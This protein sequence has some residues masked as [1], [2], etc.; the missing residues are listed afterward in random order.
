MGLV[1][2]LTRARPPV[3]QRT[4]LAVEQRTSLGNGDPWLVQLLG[5]G[6]Q[7]SAGTWVTP[8]SAL[9]LSVVFRAVTIIATGV[10]MLPLVLYRRLDEG[11]KK[12]ATDFPLYS[13]LHDAPNK[14]Q[15]SFEWREMM[16]GHLLLRGNAYSEIFYRGDGSIAQLVP[17]N[18]DRTRAFKAADGRVWYE[19]KPIIG[20]LRIIAA[21]EMFHLRGFSSDGLT[22]LSPI[23]LQREAVGLAMAAEEFQARFFSNDATPPIALT[24]PKT[25]TDQ[26]AR[27]LKQAWQEAQAGL[28]NAHKVAV[29]EEGLDVKTIGITNRD[30]QFL[31]LRKFQT[32]EIARMFGVPLHMLA[33]LDRATF[34]NIE[35]QSLEFVIYC[36][37]P[38]LR[39]W[40]SAISR[41]LLSAKSRSTLF[42]EFLVDALLRGDMVSR[43][44]AYSQA[45][46]RGVLCPNEV[47]EKENLNPRPGGDAYHIA[48]NIVG[49]TLTEP[50]PP[51]TPP[52]KPD[53]D[54]ED[55]E[56]RARM[57]TTLRR[58]VRANADRL[59]R[60]EVT[61]LSRL[62]AKHP[63]LHN[64]AL[65]IERFYG[66]QFAE[67]DE[68]HIR[69]S[70][71]QLRDAI[72][73]GDPTKVDE[74]LA[75]WGRTRV[76]EIT[77][78][79]MT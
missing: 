46:D 73:T 52:A 7:T 24:H 13:T 57:R 58:L 29:L 75:R 64:L 72:A 41:D 61:A 34:S 17:L 25:L 6:T 66:E 49:T 42:A 70:R 74:L 31:E 30:A 68:D 76:E 32:S 20:K 5:R 63:P 67:A 65:S 59:V 44:T 56:D 26:A 2:M 55:E 69:E 40:E 21:E 39:R 62:A 78:S 14:W 36:L 47:R 10:A 43:W 28:P 54:P 38:H 3:E 15:T 4:S 11:G 45:L 71:R 12:R 60:K 77:T 48:A 50:Q 23:A 22:G 53:D 27:R 9:R 18:P 37:M 33:D 8:E 1:A 19:F 35:Q 79:Q 51:P 16:T